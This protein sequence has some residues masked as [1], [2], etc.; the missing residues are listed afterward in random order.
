MEASPQFFLFL[1]INCFN[2]SL[3]YV[4]MY[5]LVEIFQIWY[6]LSQI[7]IS[8]FLATISFIFYRMIIF[9]ESS[10]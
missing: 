1:T 6:M 3:N 8:F 4:G 2:L 5:L 7:I 9:Q 10:L